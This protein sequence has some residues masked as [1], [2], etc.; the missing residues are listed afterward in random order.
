LFNTW[1]CHEKNAE[2]KKEKLGA[3]I[4]CPVRVE[5]PKSAA[6]KSEEEPF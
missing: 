4:F 2:E 5:A 6:A 1:R 3:F